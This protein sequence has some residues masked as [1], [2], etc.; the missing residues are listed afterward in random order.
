M[1]VVRLVSI[2]L[3]K[4]GV[5]RLLGSG[6]EGVLL[7]VVVW[8]REGGAEELFCGLYVKVWGEDKGVVEVT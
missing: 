2:R 7:E 6:W 4:G 5:G 1:D 8:E 3:W